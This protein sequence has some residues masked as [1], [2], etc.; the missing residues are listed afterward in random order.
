MARSFAAVGCLMA[1]RSARLH[2]A[3]RCPRIRVSTCRRSGS[4]STPASIIVTGMLRL[5]SACAQ[6]TPAGPD[7]TMQITRR[8]SFAAEAEHAQEETREDD[9]HAER[10]DGDGGNHEAQPFGVRQLAK[11]ETAQMI[12][13]G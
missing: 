10:D 6:A 2:S 3:G 8:P 5:T 1:S 7:P 11:L 4:I 9:L 12:D 13:G